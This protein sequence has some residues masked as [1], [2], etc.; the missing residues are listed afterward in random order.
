MDVS[1]DMNSYNEKAPR[2]AGLFHVL[3]TL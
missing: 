3:L 1:E 2:Q